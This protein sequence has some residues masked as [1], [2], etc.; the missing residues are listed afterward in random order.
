VSAAVTNPELF[1]ALGALCEPPDPSHRAVTEALELTDWPRANDGTDVFTVQL[2]PYAS[3]YLGHEGMLGGEAGARVAGFWHAVGYDVPA[4]PDHLAALLGLYAALSEAEGGET[5]PARR[6]L[7]RQ[8][9]SALLWE[10][11]LTWVPAYAAAVA[12]TGQ[13]AHA[14]WGALLTEALLNEGAQLDPPGTP[15]AHLVGVPDLPSPEEGLDAYVRALL[16]PVRSGVVLT[17]SDLVRL[18]RTLRIGLRIGDRAFVLRRLLEADALGVL[19]QLEERARTWAHR[20]ERLAGTV[21]PSARHWKTR[22][23]A[24]AADAH[25]RRTLLQEVLADVR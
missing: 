3:I 16:A 17:R 9:R 10:H 5:D 7:R 22:A 11:L 21:G 2:L 12:D 19:G 23:A 18:A 13:P 14:D 6:L 24:T 15:P 8:A 4:E 20:H 1:R 25:H